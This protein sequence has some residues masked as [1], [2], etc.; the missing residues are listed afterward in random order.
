M[1]NAHV[2]N[3]PAMEN[4]ERLVYRPSLAPFRQ[5]LHQALHQWHRHAVHLQAA[6]G[7]A[8]AQYKVACDGGMM[9]AVIPL[10]LGKIAV[11]GGLT[12]R[13]DQVVERTYLSESESRLACADQPP[14]PTA[15]TR[16]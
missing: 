14:A 16:L 10:P 7:G 12:E 8:I 13:L 4:L 15:V 9:V 6:N 1:A 3:S 5:R 11:F 2:R